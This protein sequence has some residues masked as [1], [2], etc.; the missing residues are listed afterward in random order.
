MTDTSFIP[1]PQGMGVAEVNELSAP[2][3]YIGVP[4]GDVYSVLPSGQVTQIAPPSGG[5]QPVK[6]ISFPFAWNTAGIKDG[7]TFYTP[8]A[9]DVLAGFNVSTFISTP[10][11]GTTPTV[12]VGF[13]TDGGYD[14][15]ING[16]ATVGNTPV[17]GGGGTFAPYGSSTN[18]I[19]LD[20]TEPLQVSI[21]DGSRGGDS[22][23]TAGEGLLTA[24]IWLAP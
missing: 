8:N 20:G 22:G 3:L 23:A 16:D 9:G 7:V 19:L 2:G 6:V 10:F 12:S 1:V 11:N 4:S 21:N 13:P 18:E 14:I 24:I 5:S 17:T 15:L